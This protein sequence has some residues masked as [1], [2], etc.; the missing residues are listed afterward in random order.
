MIDELGAHPN[1]TT[2]LYGTAYAVGQKIVGS[3]YA[4]C[5]NAEIATRAGVIMA[6][7]PALEVGALAPCQIGVI[8]EGARLPAGARVGAFKCATCHRTSP[9]LFS[10]DADWVAQGGQA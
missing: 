5:R 4:R 7:G 2:R 10:P 8:K 1:T 9:Q 6:I 3:C